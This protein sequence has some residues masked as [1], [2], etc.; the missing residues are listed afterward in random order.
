LYTLLQQDLFLHGIPGAHF[1]CGKSKG[2]LTRALML[3]LLFGNSGSDAPRDTPS[4]IGVALE[5]F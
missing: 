4:K 2:D 3:V 5:Y 1:P